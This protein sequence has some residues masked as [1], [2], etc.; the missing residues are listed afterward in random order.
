MFIY[1]DN[2]PAD[3]ISLRGL[4]IDL[5]SRACRANK[6]LARVNIILQLRKRTTD[7]L[8]TRHHQY[9]RRL[10]NPFDIFARH[11]PEVFTAEG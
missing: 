10:V 3:C 6:V 2:F 4:E 7:T 9:F 5:E 11:I 8:V 1:R